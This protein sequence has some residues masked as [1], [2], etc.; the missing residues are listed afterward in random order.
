M[1]YFAPFKALTPPPHLASQIASPPYDVINRQ[2][3][4]A[5]IDQHPKSLLRITRPDALLDDSVSLYASQA[6][7]KAV[8]EWTFFKQEGWIVAQDQPHFYIYAQHMGEHVQMGLV[9]VASAQDYW[10]DRIKKHEFTLP[11]KEDDRMRQIEVLKAH[12]GPIFLTYPAQTSIDQ[13]IR[14]LSQTEPQIDFVANDQ[15]RHQVWPVSDEASIHLLQEAFQELDA[16]YIAD[17][18][19]RAAA[20]SRVGKDASLQEAK[21]QFLAV[22]FP[23]NQLQV[24]AYNRVVNDLNQWTV[25]SL[26]TEIEKDFV[27]TPLNQAQAPE[28]PHQWSMYLDSQWFSLTARSHLQEKIAAQPTTERLDVSVLQNFIL[29]PL[30][31]IEDPRTSQ[32]IQFVGGIRGLKALEEQANQSKGVAFALYPTSV[33]ELMAIAD[34]GQVMPPKSTWFEPKLRS[35]LMMSSYE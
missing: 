2:E 7:E 8:S 1:V 14:D 15:V 26:K 32:R 31:G 21:G 17:G 10:D 9:G 18:H 3:A 20:A 19:H 16:L 11:K 35:G 4:K 22:A 12:L 34:E 25:E 27:L 23:H 33:E 24:L 5:Y 30:L 6:Y 13:L 28:T 29:N